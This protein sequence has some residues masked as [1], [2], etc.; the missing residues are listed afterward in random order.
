MN[1]MNIYLSLRPKSKTVLLSCWFLIASKTL[2]IN[3]WNNRNEA[4]SK[5]LSRRDILTGAAIFTAY[6]STISN[7]SEKRQGDYKLRFPTLFAPIYG[8]AYRKTI[9]RSLLVQNDD[10]NTTIWAMEQNLELGPLQTPLRCVVIRLKN[11]SLWVHSPIAPTEEFFELVESCGDKVAHVVVPTYALEHKVF[12]KD[13]LQRWPD[14][15]LWISPG[16]FSYPINVSEEFVFGKTVSG[17]LDAE[18]HSLIPWSDEIEYATLAGGTFNIGG[19]STTL[20]ETAFFH[21]ASKSLI[22]TDSL[23]RIPKTVPPLNDPENL[24][25]ISKRSTSDPMPN[26]TP[27]A[28]LIGWEKTALLVSY[29][30]P[31]HEEFDPN[32]MGVVT[33]TEGWHDNFNALAGRLVVPPVV[34]TLLYSQNP[35]K[36]GEWVD[37]VVERWEF[38]QIVPAHFDAPI[39]AT[40][41]DF[42]NAFLFLKDDTLDAFPEKD[43]ARGLKTIADVALKVL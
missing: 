22:V 10:N 20:F 4:S 36:V 17:V 14:A 24:L 27:T 35:S 42:S 7:A 31:E 28:R 18:S 11:N 39:T 19:K 23:A 33:W 16:Q 9:K 43:L 13:A 29:F 6:T 30:F 5:F 37:E 21:K 40:P 12:V 15:E 26:D 1:T 38:D 3:G 8:E 34:R 25:L 41:R 32:K 2:T